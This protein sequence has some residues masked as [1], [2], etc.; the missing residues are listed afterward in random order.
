LSQ[1]STVSWALTSEESFLAISIPS[2]P[3]EDSRAGAEKAV[4]LKEE[5]SAQ[6]V[7]VVHKEG[8]DP[9]LSELDGGGHPSRPATDHQGL[10]FDF[11]DFPKREVFRGGRGLG[12]AGKRGHLHSRLHQGHAG[13]HRPAIGHDQTLGA[14]AV[15]AK[16]P[17]R[18]AIFGMVAEDPNAVGEKGGGDGFARV[19]QK[20][21]SGK[22]KTEGLRAADL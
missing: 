13:L 7:F 2:C 9:K 22:E 19:S 4:G 18:R 11:L 16:D 12:K 3:G 6:G 21:F 10:H 14:L 8:F 15:G 5:F 20:F 17:L 1:I